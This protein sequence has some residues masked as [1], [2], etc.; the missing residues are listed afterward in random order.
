MGG[1]KMSKII[2]I[3]MLDVRNI[4]EDLAQEITKIEDIGTLVESDESR[5]LLKNCEKINVASTIKVPKE[6]NII[7]QNGKMKVD[8]DYLEGLVKSVSIMVNGIL[9]FENDIDIKLFDDKVYSVLLNGKLICTKRLAVAVQSKGIINGKIVNYNND[10]KFFS[11]SFKLTN[12]FLKSLKSDSKLAFEQLIIIDDIDIKL[13]K[14]KISN[15]QILDKVVMLDEYEDEISPYIDEYYTVNKTLIPQGSGGVQYIDGDISIDDISIRKY[16]HNVLYVDGDA[17]IYL[18]DNIVFDQYI[19]HLICDAVVC[20]E[21]TYEIIKDGLDKNVEVEIIKGKLLNNKGKLILSGNLEE[22]VTIRNMGKLIFDENLDYE[23]FNENVASI[24]NYGLIEVP[25][26]KLNTV[27]NKI[28]D[29]Y[30]K[31]MTP[32]EEKAEE[33]NNDMEKILYGNV[34]ELRL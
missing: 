3:G 34:A 30:G 19:E 9:T 7:I 28:T 1:I 32:K 33:S 23:K 12:S 18:K 31:I 24:I 5:V 29:N 20:D 13:L 16:D 6:I 10:Y 22:E 4:S 21:K 15:I 2:G 17:E 25:E 14:E 26:D 8:R 11:G 27:N